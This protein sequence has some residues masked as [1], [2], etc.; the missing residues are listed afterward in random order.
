MPAD[1]KKVPNLESQPIKPISMPEYRY[2]EYVTTEHFSSADEGRRARQ[3]PSV[4][5]RGVVLN[6]S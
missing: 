1:T 4:D 2:Q 5:L 6:L 3:E